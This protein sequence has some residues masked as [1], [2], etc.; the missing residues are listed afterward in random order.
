MAAMRSRPTADSSTPGIFTAARPS[1]CSGMLATLPL[2][3]IHPNSDGL[4]VDTLIRSPDSDTISV[5]LRRL[6]P[7]TAPV[8]T[9][10]VV[11]IMI[12]GTGIRQR[13]RSNGPGR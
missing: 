5:D 9:A 13:R 3:E 11:A 7:G 12:S 10:G 8:E 1:S 4:T 6:R 2:T